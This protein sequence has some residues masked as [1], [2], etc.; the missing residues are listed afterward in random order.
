MERPGSPSAW[1]EVFLAPRGDT[2]VAQIKSR[3]LQRACTLA[4]LRSLHLLLLQAQ[5]LQF[6]DQFR[7]NSKK[8][9]NKQTNKNLQLLPTPTW[10]KGFCS[11]ELCCRQT[12]LW[13]SSVVHKEELWFSRGARSREKGSD[14][15]MREYR[16][17]TTP[18]SISLVIFK[19][20]V[21]N[22]VPNIVLNKESNP[23]NREE[24]YLFSF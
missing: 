19:N 18:A 13:W 12:S 7:K 11:K 3:T 23:P 17:K 10:P 5:L 6:P 8:Q 9:T 21:W 2:W 14:P 4:S 1:S 24:A 16:G 22:H 15:K 20:I